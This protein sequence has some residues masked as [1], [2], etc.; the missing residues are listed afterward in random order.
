MYAGVEHRNPYFCSYFKNEIYFLSFTFKVN[1][2]QHA[3]GSIHGE[4]PTELNFVRMAVMNS[5]VDPWI[6]ILFRKEVL[7]LVITALERLT[8]RQFHM[9]RGLMG[10]P[11]TGDSNKTPATPR[12]T[13]TSDPL[14]ATVTASSDDGGVY[15]G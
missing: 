14:H 2:L 15:Q 4:G 3:S 11:E 8:G 9:K 7:L 5:V 10:F 6:Y 12:A 1:I 13:P